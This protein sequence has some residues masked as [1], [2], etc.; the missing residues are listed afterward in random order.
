MAVL[1]IG[2]CRALVLESRR[3]LRYDRE[4]AADGV[5][6]YVVDTAVATG[7]APVRVVDTTPGTALG[8]DDAPLRAGLTWTDADS[9][10]SVTV[11]SGTGTADTVRVTPGHLSATAS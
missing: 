7:R 11:T 2:G 4:I 8:L 10:T 6:V 1:P 3:P 9:G 5:L